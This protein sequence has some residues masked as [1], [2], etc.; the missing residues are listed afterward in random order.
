VLE[1]R[2]LYKEYFHLTH[3]VRKSKNTNVFFLSRKQFT[4]FA[5]VRRNFCCLL[6]FSLLFQI[7]GS[8]ELYC[9]FNPLI[10]QA[11]AMETA[12]RLLKLLR[13]DEKRV[14][15]NIAPGLL[16]E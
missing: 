8:F 4:L 9:T 14:F 15:F 7:T 11:S 1:Q 6:H 3:L 12:E 2:I 13:K 5:W 10:T 16:N